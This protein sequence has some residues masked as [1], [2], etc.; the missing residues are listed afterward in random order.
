MQANRKAGR[1]IA[2]HTAILMVAAMGVTL[3]L[4]R[5]AA[6]Q[7]DQF[8]SVANAIS[9]SVAKTFVGVLPSSVTIAPVDQSATVTSGSNSV[10]ANSASKNVFGVEVY[11][12]STIND[13]TD[14]SDTAAL[15]VGGATA[16]TGAGS[17]LGGLVT[18]KSNSAPLAC[19]P[20]T[21]VTGQ[22]DCESTQITTGLTI[23]GATISTGPY[24]AGSSFTVTGKL[25]DPQ[26][27]LVAGI[28]SF[29]GSLVLQETHFSGVETDNVVLSE[30][31]IHLVGD[32][33][34]KTVGLVSLFSTHYDLAVGGTEIGDAQL[35]RKHRTPHASVHAQVE[36]VPVAA[37]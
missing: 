26:C 9:G 37:P 34:C 22:V 1:T 31:G 18:W 2:T 12:L 30:V 23:N 24:P 16:T 19:S 10:P 8:S 32:A 36:P 20:D 3:G 4:S 14:D 21:T 15:D 7:T 33:T 27:L 5:S 29:S 35:Y 17:L 13:S 28:E 6:A 25:T 11:N